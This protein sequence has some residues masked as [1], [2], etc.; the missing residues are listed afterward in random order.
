MGDITMSYVNEFETIGDW[1]DREIYDVLLRDGHDI[2]ELDN[3]GMALSAL[4]EGYVLTDGP[5]KPFLELTRE[6]L[7]AG[8][9]HFKEEL[10]GWLRGGKLLEVSNNLSTIQGFSFDPDDTLFLEDNNKAYVM[11]AGIII[12]A[13]DTY[14]NGFCKGYYVIPYQD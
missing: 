7:V 9:N 12:E 11:L 10:N 1:L 8:Y 3:W 13:K 5:D 2:D 14:K 6:D 4:S